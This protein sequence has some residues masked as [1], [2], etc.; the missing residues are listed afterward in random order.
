MNTFHLVTSKFFVTLKIHHKCS[1]DLLLVVYKP[2]VYLTQSRRNRFSWHLVNCPLHGIC[3]F[4]VSLC[5]RFKTSHRAK[6]FSC[7]NEFDLHEIEPVGRWHFH[8][9]NLAWRL[10]LTQRYLEM[11]ATYWL[12]GKRS[13]RD[14]PGVICT[15]WGTGLLIAGLLV[16][17]LP[18]KFTA[19]AG[20]VLLLIS[21]L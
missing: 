18:N 6:N 16:I 20:T 5:L 7:E 15:G 11:E 13:D 19:P 2:A 9:N 17:W 3:H 4:R 10:V 1:C 21:K 8:T 12:P 14:T